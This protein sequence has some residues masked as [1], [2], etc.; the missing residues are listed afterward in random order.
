MQPANT[1]QI[2]IDA[3]NSKTGAGTLDFYAKKYGT[4]TDALAKMNNISN[5]NMIQAGGSLYVPTPI[6]QTTTGINAKDNQNVTDLTNMS[7]GLPANQQP[8]NVNGTGNMETPVVGNPKPPTAEEK[9]KAEID[10]KYAGEMDVV[11]NTFESMRATAN[12]AS[13]ALMDSIK[14]KYEARKIQMEDINK[15]SLASKEIMGNRS[16]RARYASL[17]QE[18]ILTGEELDGQARLSALNA[19]E[20][21][22]LAEAQM[23]QSK[24]DFELLDTK[25]TRLHEIGQDKI[26]ELTNLNKLALDHEQ[27]ALQKIKD[28]R[29]Q[30]SFESDEMYKKSSSISGAMVD[31]FENLKTDKARADFIAQMAEKHGVDPDVLLGDVNKA[32]TESKKDA[33]EMENVRSLIYSRYKEAN[34]EEEGDFGEDPADTP[35][36]QD[37]FASLDRAIAGNLKNTAGQ[38]ILDEGKKLFTADVWKDI[39]ARA[40]DVGITQDAM[41]KKYKDKLY[42]NKY[43]FAK[44]YGWTEEEF[45]K[46]KKY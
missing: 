19:E 39:V 36:G 9:A 28:D 17:I 4:T 20:L 46:Y 8:Q 40:A 25:M 14:A 13:Q 45:N 24:Q 11:N 26:N 43:K 1:T 37:F 5:P 34:D 12:A 15:R 27:L 18:G 33:L 10:A 35:E 3:Y 22:L 44:N 21:S 23:A 29:E 41:V 16:G 7:S 38:P 32:L 31:S 2:K 42:L 6:I 30:K